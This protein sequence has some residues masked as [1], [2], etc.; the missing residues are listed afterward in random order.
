MGSELGQTAQS[1]L[2]QKPDIIIII[3][4]REKDQHH[5]LSGREGGSSDSISNND[6]S[7]NICLN[8]YHTDIINHPFSNL[9]FHSSL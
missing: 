6:K 8:E 2:D 5:L 7:I 4:C 3:E 9:L 1:I